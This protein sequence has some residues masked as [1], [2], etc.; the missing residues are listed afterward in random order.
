M[1]RFSK[2]SYL[3]TLSE[4][5]ITPLLDLAFVLLIIFVITTPLLEQSINLKLP[6]GGTPDRFINRQNIRIVEISPQGVYL[7]ERQRMRSLA[8]LERALVTAYRANTNLIVRIRADENGPYKHVAAVLDVCLRNGIT[9][10]SL[11]TEP[12][13]T[14]TR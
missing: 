13:G 12:P 5:N 8:E 10:F 6:T 3:V 4:I 1:R 11:G 14:T 7:F 2:R 9:K